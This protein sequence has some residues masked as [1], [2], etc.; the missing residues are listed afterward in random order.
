MMNQEKAG[1]DK[2]IKQWEAQFKKKNGREPTADDKYI[3]DL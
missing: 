2:D 1:I 3:K